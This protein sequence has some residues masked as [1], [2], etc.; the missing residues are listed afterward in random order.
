MSNIPKEI[1]IE[2]YISEVLSETYD[3]SPFSVIYTECN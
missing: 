1:E 3:I 2:R